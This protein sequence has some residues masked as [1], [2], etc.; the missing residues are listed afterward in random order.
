MTSHMVCLVLDYHQ[1]N[2]LH[3]APIGDEPK[4][5][6]TWVSSR[7]SPAKYGMTANSGHRNRPWQLGVVSRDLESFHGNERILLIRVQ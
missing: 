2:P 7:S 1:P 5:S 3:R 4:V 6:T